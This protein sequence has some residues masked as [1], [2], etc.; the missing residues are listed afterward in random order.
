AVG[1]GPGTR[2]SARSLTG[3]RTLGTASGKRLLDVVDQILDVLDAYRQ[4]HEIGWTYRPGP[5]DARAMLGQA[6]D[7]SQRRRALKDTKPRRERHRRALASG[8]AQRHHSAKSAAHLLRG[9]AMPGMRWQAWIEHMRESGMPDK[10]LR[11]RESVR[12]RGRH[13]KM[14]V[15]HPAQQKPRLERAEHGAAATARVA[16]AL[17]Q[18]VVARRRERTG[19]H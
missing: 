17:P 1:S 10:M 15:P 11:D 19:D 8:K 9:D 12:G 18:L 16:D 14:H 4:P 6:L 2:R 3:T 7:R 5:F 13:R